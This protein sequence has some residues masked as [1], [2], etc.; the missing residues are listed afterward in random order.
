M[1]A[2][3]L[4]LENIKLKN[5]IEVLEVSII[6]NLIGSVHEAY[7]ILL[8]YVDVDINDFVNGV[9][10]VILQTIADTSYSEFINYFDSEELLEEMVVYRTE[11]D[12]YDFVNIFH[13]YTDRSNSEIRDFINYH[14][15]VFNENPEEYYKFL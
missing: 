3:G 7:Q 8:E 15:D 14:C 12:P 13:N 5:F 1:D 10:E 4:Y 9:N 6:G 2:E 11:I